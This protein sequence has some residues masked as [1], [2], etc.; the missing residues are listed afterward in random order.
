VLDLGGNTFFWKLAERGG[1]ELPRITIVN[2]YP[3]GQKPPEYIQAWVMA[4]G[5]NLPFEDKSY[6]IVFCNSVIEH[7]GNWESQVMFANE[8][9][10]V[11]RGYFVQTP[12][13]DFF[14]EPH[15]ITPFIHW[16]PRKLQEKLIRNFTVWGLVT[17]PSAEKCVEFL[18]EVRLLNRDDMESLFP[19][20]EVTFETFLGLRKSILALK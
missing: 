14:I 3:P 1:L 11:G 16:F 13:R 7:L 6:D 12:N 19:D 15:L 10:R 2:L 17:R 18:N 9:R 4:D 5:R 20:S 8:I